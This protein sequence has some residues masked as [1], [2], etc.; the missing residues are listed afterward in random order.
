M[1]RPDLNPLFRFRVDP[2]VKNA[3]ARKDE[4]V[5]AITVNHS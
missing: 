5:P 2:A 1:G 3:A 4:R